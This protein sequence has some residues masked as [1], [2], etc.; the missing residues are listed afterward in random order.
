MK[1]LLNRA[2][3]VARAAQKRRV[4]ELASDWR[5]AGA[6]VR[7]GSDQVIVEMRGLSRRVLDP[8]MRFVGLGR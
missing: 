5:G 6:F 7:T 2:E 4:E 3:A 1:A 8:V